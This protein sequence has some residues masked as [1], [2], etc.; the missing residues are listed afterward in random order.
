MNTEQT[1]TLHPD[2]LYL[3]T[4]K[5]AIALARFLMLDLSTDFSRLVYNSGI[6]DE[7][8]VAAFSNK[9]KQAIP[10]EQ[11]LLPAS[12]MLLLYTCTYIYV[13][14]TQQKEAFY[15][16]LLAFDTGEIDNTDHF[17]KVIQAAQLAL[18]ESIETLMKDDKLLPQ[19]KQVLINT[20]GSL[21]AL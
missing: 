13:C 16:W 4:A 15:K 1:Y 9:M 14:F 19:R 21:P 12:E 20:F 17:R 3:S 11:L 18:T 7:D 5:P 6:L 10:G 2:F 8:E